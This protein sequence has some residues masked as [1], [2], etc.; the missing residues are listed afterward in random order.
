MHLSYHLL[1]LAV[2]FIFILDYG[3]DIRQKVNS[4]D[5]LEFKMGDKAAETPRNIN[6]IFASRNANEHTVQWWFKKSYKGDK[7]LEVEEHSSW[8]LEIY[9]DQLRA[10][11]KLILLQLHK[12]F[13]KNSTST[14]LWSFCI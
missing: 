6:S 4:S 2:Y 10:S 13:P 9:N 5:F 7:S 11:S 1:L 14:I 8:P 3:N 12:K